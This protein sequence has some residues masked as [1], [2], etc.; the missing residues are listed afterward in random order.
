MVPAPSNASIYDEQTGLPLN[1]TWNLEIWGDELASNQT[2]GYDDVADI[3]LTVGNEYN[4]RYW[5]NNYVTRNI[6]QVFNE[7][8]TATKLYTLNSSDSLLTLYTLTDTA[9][10]P[11][12]GYTL[13]V[14][15]KMMPTNTWEIVEQSVSDSNGQGTI[16]LEPYNVQYMFQ[17]EDS[18]GTVVFSSSTPQVIPQN[19]IYFRVNLLGNQLSNYFVLNNV[20]TD[21]TWTN[22]TLN[23]TFT[24]SDPAQDVA[25]GR[26]E[27]TRSNDLLTALICNSTGTG[28]LGTVTCS[29]ASYANDT[30]ATFTAN[31]YIEANGTYYLA[32]SLS[33]KNANTLQT[34]LGLFGAFLTLLIVGTFAMMGLWNPAAAIVFAYI[35][36]VISYLFGLIPM[37]WTYVVGIGAIAAIAAWRVKT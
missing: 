24:W 10:I 22:S 31:A 17:I 15:R 14:Y 30:T 1:I 4:Y 16:S 19:S 9:S 13:S 3:N 11:L 36:L 2:V 23:F 34:S 8:A 28:Y 35:G 29:L 7:S 6:F 26:L 33:R 12:A 25:F 18:A 27:V 5:S 32:G 21:L 20:L 37:S